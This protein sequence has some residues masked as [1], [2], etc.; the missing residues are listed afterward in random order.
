MSI[1]IIGTILNELGLKPASFA[2][3]IG[4]HP[5]QIYDLISGKTKSISNAMADKILNKYPQFNR[6]YLLTGEGDILVSHESNAVYV[7]EAN[8]EDRDIVPMVEFIPF[9]ATASYVDSYGTDI[10]EPEY[11]GVIPQSGEHLDSS[12]KVFEVSGES[13]LPG[14]KP[15]A[16]ILV[17]EI[18]QSK[19]HYAEGVVVVILS[20]MI[21][22]KRITQNALNTEN[23][24]ELS[25]DNP[26]YGK[27]IIQLADIKAMFKAIRKVSE[28]ID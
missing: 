1:S 9:S 12:Y 6:L 27:K 23:W 17:R 2:R 25:S 26:K 22:I 20:D 10:G 14:I 18:P 28:P 19:W 3:L 24:V 13:M 7:G 8:K 5:T 21:L 11:I 15:M 16:R 4:V